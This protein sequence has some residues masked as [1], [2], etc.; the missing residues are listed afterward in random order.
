MVAVLKRARRPLT[1]REIAEQIVAEEPGAFTGKTPDRS[2]Y[3]I[4][5]RKEKRRRE[6]GE[7]VLL[8]VVKDERTTRY[9]LA[10]NANARRRGERE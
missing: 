2:L 6:R 4:M 7:A 5:Y 1:M 3:S 10:G 8:A 9:R